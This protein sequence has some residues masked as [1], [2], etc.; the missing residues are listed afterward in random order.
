MNVIGFCSDPRRTHSSALSGIGTQSH[1][2]PQ[3]PPTFGSW[4]FNSPSRHHH[5]KP[6]RTRLPATLL[7]QN[8]KQGR[9][10]NWSCD[11]LVTG[12]ER[13]TTLLGEFQGAVSELLPQY[14]PR[15]VRILVRSSRGYRAGR[16]G[17]WPDARGAASDKCISSDGRSSDANH[18]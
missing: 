18:D 10:K 13:T 7:A 1:P 8:P 5:K 9:G 16:Q 6:R 2:F 17:R 15:G 11:V 3:N 4:G 14:V 12:R